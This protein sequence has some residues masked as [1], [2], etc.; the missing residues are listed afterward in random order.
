MCTF[1]S[2]SVTKFNNY[3]HRVTTQ[4]QLINKYYI[5]LLY[6]LFG[7]NTDFFISTLKTKYVINKV[8]L[9]SLIFLQMQVFY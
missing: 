2:S 7:R 6:F 3:C 5:I 8:L 9:N 1:I 4:L